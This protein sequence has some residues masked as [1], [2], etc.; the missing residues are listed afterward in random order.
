[1]FFEALKGL[2]NNAALLMALI[3]LYELA[4]LRPGSKWR[5][6]KVTQGLAIGLMGIALISTPL[7][8]A[9][10]VV[11]DA[12]TILLSLSGFFCRCTSSRCRGSCRRSSPRQ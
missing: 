4:L 1:M 6:T 2:I 12:R 3:L 10:G 11:F 9:P 7:H 8:F 5:I